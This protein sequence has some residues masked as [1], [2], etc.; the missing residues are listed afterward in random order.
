MVELFDQLTLWHWCGLALVLLIVEAVAFNGYL[1]WIG[2][3]ALIVS[4][5]MVL[6]DIGWEAQLLVFAV[7]SVVF[8]WLWYRHW[9]KRPVKTEA[10]LL[11]QRSSQFIG[12]TATVTQPIQNGQGRVKLDDS[13]WRVKG[14]DAAE[15]EQVRVI[16]VVDEL[17]LEVELVR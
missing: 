6:F 8:T 9:V 4:A 12:R 1:L 14:P 17:T 3:S 13:I 2:L 11:N 15:G 5:L 10:P 7:C 16:A